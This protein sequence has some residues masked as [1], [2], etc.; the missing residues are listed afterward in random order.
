M[1]AA[2]AEVLPLRFVPYGEALR[3]HVDELRLIRARQ[4]RGKTDLPAQ[5]GSRS[6]D[7]VET[8]DVLSPLVR[9]VR[10]FQA[11]RRSLTRRLDALA[12]RDV[13]FAA[14][15][16]RINDSLTRV[17]RA[18]LLP[19]G[20]A[21]RSWFKHAIYAPGVT[22]GYGAWPLP[23]VRQALEEK[24]ADQLKLPV[25]Q[26]AAAI[27]RATGGPSEGPGRDQGRA[28]GRSA[29]PLTAESARHETLIQKRS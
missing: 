7:A 16:R 10:G 4:I 26:T 8:S 2:A 17:E 9:A 11:R 20:L 1:R 22:T 13:G 25:D 12:G 29:E 6:P 27:D 3:D 23:A 5:A 28:R 14:G 21:G 24:K 18:F 19:A 15:T